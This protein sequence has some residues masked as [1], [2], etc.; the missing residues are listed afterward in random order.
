M[1]VK[2]ATDGQHFA[3]HIS[4]CIF[5]KGNVWILTKTSLNLFI[6][7]RLIINQ[8]W[9]RQWLGAE[10]VPSHY[11]S[12]RWFS[13]GDAYMHRPVLLSCH[14]LCLNKNMF[15]VSREENSIGLVAVT[16][17]LFSQNSLQ[18]LN[19]RELGYITYRV[20]NLEIFMV[21]IWTTTL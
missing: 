9:F 5:F 17:L 12:Q 11:L 21:F 19:V 10:Q 20:T 16:S 18:N 8:N 14:C 3:Y 1:L 2:G 13:S 4:N 15:I 6:R 7:V